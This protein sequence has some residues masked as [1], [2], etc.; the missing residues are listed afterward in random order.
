MSAPRALPRG[1]VVLGVEGLAL[2]DADRER[3]AHPLVGGVILFARNFADPAQLAAL[4]AEI[5]ALRAPRLLICV[6]HEGGR[7]QRFRERLHADPA[8]AHAGRALGSRRRRGGGGGAAVGETIARE[9]RAHGVDFS[10]TPVL[11][12]DFGASPP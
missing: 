7:V 5:R 6:D 11:D 9:L 1:P 8:D 10:F 2:T 12:L 4:T 3:L